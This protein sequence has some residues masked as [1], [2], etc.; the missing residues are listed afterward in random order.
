MKNEGELY[1][2][3]IYCS[4]ISHE[5]SS[6]IPIKFIKNL[7]IKVIELIF[8]YKLLHFL[9]SITIE[10]MLLEF[11]QF[12]KVFNLTDGKLTTLA[13]QYNEDYTFNGISFKIIINNLDVVTGIN[14]TFWTDDKMAKLDLELFNKYGK[15]VLV[16]SLFIKNEYG[17]MERYTRS[18]ILQSQDEIKD[19]LI[20]KI[21]SNCLYFYKFSERISPSS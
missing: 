2:I 17:Q 15:F 19:I 14:M 9:C 3:F 18:D 1:K 13:K 10:Q 8:R 4:T 21:Y 20:D 12:C 7:V 16:T 11:A 5:L 6:R